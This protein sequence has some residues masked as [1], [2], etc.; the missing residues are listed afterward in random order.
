[1]LVGAEPG[2]R[3]N[4]RRGLGGTAEP[5]TDGSKERNPRG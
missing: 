1:M 3:R 2:W 5:E 4:L